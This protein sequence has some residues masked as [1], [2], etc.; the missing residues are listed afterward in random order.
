MSCSLNERLMINLRAALA[1]ATDELIKL[2]LFNVV[3][4]FFR[5]TNVWKQD[6]EINL[7]EGERDYALIM[8]PNT[9]VVR[10]LSVS[11]N[12]A[13]VP[14]QSQITAIVSGAGILPADVL[15]PDSDAVYLPDFTDKGPDDIFSYAIYRPD[16]VTIA[17]VDAQ[18][19]Q[20]P[21]KVS[22]AL[23]VA[24]GC[25]ECDCEDWS[26]PDWMYDMFFTEWQSG[27]LGAMYLMPA[28]PW[29]NERAGIMHSRRWRNA[30]GFRKQEQQN[31]G[32]QYNTPAWR[33][34]R[35]WA[36]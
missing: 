25:V 15:F 23:T 1:G 33:F 6:A 5:R 17:S 32:F 22:Y 30:M 36:R 27:V 24:K 28:K 29:T 4:E 19:A 34:P 2:Q 13:G 9:T 14:S 31:G 18:A 12:G 3:D 20:Y 35:T 10:M 11:H 8:P 21:L 26:I 7:T 16:Y